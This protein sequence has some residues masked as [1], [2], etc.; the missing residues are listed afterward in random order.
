MAENPQTTKTHRQ[1]TDYS[2]CSLDQMTTGCPG[3]HQQTLHPAILGFAELTRRLHVAAGCSL[4]ID[5]T[6]LS[7]L[8]WDFAFYEVVFVRISAIN[9]NMK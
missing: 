9:E 4:Q 7:T 8:L 2:K 6:D 3:Y 1:E 5:G